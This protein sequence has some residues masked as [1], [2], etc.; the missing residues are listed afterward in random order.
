MSATTTTEDRADDGLPRKLS[1]LRQKLSRKAKAEPRFRF[2]ALYDRIYRLD[3]LQ[4]A[5]DKVAS[6]DGGPGLD[7]VRVVD[8][9]TREGGVQQWL[10]EIQEALRTK[11]YRPEAVRR[12]YVPKP[13]G[14][15]RPLGIPT[16]KDRVVQTAAVLILEPIFETDFRECSFGFRPGRNAHGAIRAVLEALREGRTA[17]LDAD[18]KSYF[19][20]IPHDKLM[21]CVENRIADRA[22]LNLIRMWL[23]APIEEPRDPSGGKPTR[24]RPTS[25]TPQGGVISPLLANLYLHWFDEPFHRQG[26]PATFA[27][28]KLVRYADDFVILARYMGKGVLDW[29]QRWIEERMG[30]T[31]HPE[32]TRIRH[33]TFGSDRLEFLGFSIQRRKAKRGDWTYLHTSPSPKSRS[34]ALATLRQLTAPSR[35]L[36]S[37]ETVI[38]NVNSFLRGWA[39]YFK[40]GQ[41]SQVFTYI[42]DYASYRIY[43]HLR[44]RSQRPYKIPQDRNW[45]QH[46]H[47]DLGLVRLTGAGAR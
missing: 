8:V 24:H 41:P 13:D 4:A 35:G 6:N 39:G 47:Q 44:R 17:V 23:C 32:K 31:L 29:T 12:T 28:A 21:K 20:T 37:I 1:E 46:V 3:V 11:T 45:Y 10:L 15:L 26:G 19:D 22:V 9:R 43:Q 33:V 5:F 2:Y 14:R 38:D 25:G 16:I 34:R 27:R 30:L 42:Q 40:L 36:L 7:G 18:L